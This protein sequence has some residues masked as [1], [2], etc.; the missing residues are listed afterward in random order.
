MGNNATSY[1]NVIVHT[2]KPFYIAGDTVTG[3]VYVNIVST[4]PGDILYL[5]LKGKEANLWKEPYNESYTFT[6]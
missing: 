1:G 2:D 6:N 5:K 3:H 4:F